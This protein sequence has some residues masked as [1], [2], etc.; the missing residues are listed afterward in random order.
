MTIQ[1]EVLDLINKDKNATN[2]FPRICLTKEKYTALI[3]AVEPIYKKQYGSLLVDKDTFEA[4][5]ENIVYMGAIV[6]CEPPLVTCIRKHGGINLKGIEITEP[7]TFE[8]E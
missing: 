3:E 5:F 6:S 8:E 7:I 2:L 1:Q 4:G